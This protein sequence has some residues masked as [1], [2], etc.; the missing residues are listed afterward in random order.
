MKLTSRN[1]HV[2]F[3]YTIVARLP[4][5]A[6]AARRGPHPRNCLATPLI[7]TLVNFFCQLR[8]NRNRVARK[9]C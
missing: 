4:R 7:K 2:I 3:S 1:V 8:T 9:H 5:L 6:S